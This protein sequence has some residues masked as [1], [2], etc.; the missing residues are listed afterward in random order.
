MADTLY[1]DFIV[2]H[3]SYVDYIVAPTLYVD[4]GKNS[5]TQGILNPS[6]Y[7]KN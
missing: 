3:T 4:A 5:L 1:V 2:A 6:V 7:F